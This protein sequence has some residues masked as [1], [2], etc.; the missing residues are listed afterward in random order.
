MFGMRKFLADRKGAF[1]IQ[2]ALMVVPL[3]VCTGLAVDGGRAF[4]ARY[5]LASALDAAALAVGSTTDAGADLDAIAQTWVEKNFRTPHQGPIAL[6]LTTTGPVITLQ[7]TAVIDTYFM[8]LVGQDSVTVSAE[9]EVRRGG[10]SVEVALALDITGSMDQNADD[11]IKKIVSLKAAAN[12]L[13]DTVVALPANQAPF[14]SRV[15][16][17]PWS[18]NVWAGTTPSTMAET[19]RGPISDYV[20]ASAATWRKG[21]SNTSVGATWRSGVEYTVSTISRPSGTRTRIT[22][23]GTPSTLANGDSI[24]LYTPSSGSADGSFA[25]Y[26]S[27]VYILADKSGTTTATFN[28]KDTSGNYVA[29]PGSGA[30][31]GTSWRVNECLNAACQVRISVGSGN[32]NLAAGD[33]VNVTA[34]SANY[35]FVNNASLN[36]PWVVQSTPTPTSTAGLPQRRRAHQHQRDP[37]DDRRFGRHQPG[38]LHQHLRNPGDGADRNCALHPGQRRPHPHQQCRERQLGHGDE[39]DVD[40][41]GRGAGGGRHV[42]RAD[43]LVR[44]VLRDLHRELRTHPLP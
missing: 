26:K 38:M 28:L 7:G 35:A 31:N 19:L 39:P 25:T 4:L 44:P 13:I 27:K 42:L 8:P 1:A 41:L 15:A 20:T 11:G 5:E 2:F 40:G 32:L 34:M 17:I 10:N 36:S 18:N 14:Y 21:A 12:S 43:R 22:V 6:T 29:P 3:T 9:S 33:Y 37:R 24:G 30:T 23:T 16:I